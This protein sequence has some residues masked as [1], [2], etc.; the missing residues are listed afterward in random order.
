MQFE[1]ATLARG[2]TGDLR[3]GHGPSRPTVGLKPGARGRP[4]VL[5][6]GLD[7]LIFLGGLLFT[8]ALLPQALRTVKLGRAEDLS[9]PFILMVLGGSALTLMYWLIREE[10]WVVY[11]GFIA[12]IAV[13]GLVLYYRLFPREGAV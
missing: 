1:A 7:W 4:P 13:W 3:T 10:P 12:N 8:L 2:G 9:I 5:P 11:Y 6:S